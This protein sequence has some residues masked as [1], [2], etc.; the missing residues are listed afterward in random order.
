ARAP[1]AAYSVL[2]ISSQ[3]EISGNALPVTAGS[4]LNISITLVGSATRVE[5]FAKRNGQP[6]PSAMVVL[7]PKTGESSRDLFRRDQ[8]DLDGSFSLLNVIPGSYTVCAL[9]NGWDLDWAQREVIASHCKHGRSLTV[10][11]RA[12]ASLQLDGSV[13]VD[14]R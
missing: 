3:G 2:R 1:G 10:P 9:E 5:G 11:D 8:S 12:A 13:E 14:Q 7:V 4:S 6:V